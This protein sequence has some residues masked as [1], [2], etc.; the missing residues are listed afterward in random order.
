MPWEILFLLV[1]F[2]GALHKGA[3]FKR[4]T[5]TIVDFDQIVIDDQRLE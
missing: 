1:L 5:Y 4:T 2:N 3:A